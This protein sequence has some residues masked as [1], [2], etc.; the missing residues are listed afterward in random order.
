MFEAFSLQKQRLRRTSL[1]TVNT[2]AKPHQNGREVFKLL[3]TVLFKEQ[4]NI[5]CE[6]AI[7][8]G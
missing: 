2:L 1:F 7:A 5:H 8:E 6:A 3:R 4:M